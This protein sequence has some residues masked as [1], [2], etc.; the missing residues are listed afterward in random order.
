VQPNRSERRLGA[1]CGSGRP[2]NADAH[3]TRICIRA[4]TMPFSG[5][6]A[7]GSAL[8]TSASAS[9][10]QAGAGHGRK[11]AMPVGKPIS[12]IAGPAL[13]VTV[14]IGITLPEVRM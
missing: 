3:I 11:N 1:S 5:D 9:A 7:L 13:P 8:A 14:L 6:P 10:C 4:G 2:D 12:L